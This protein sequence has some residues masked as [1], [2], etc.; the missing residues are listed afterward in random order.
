MDRQ[1]EELILAYQNGE[2]EAIEVI[3]HRYKK[4]VFNY[5]LRILSDRA[6]AEDVVSDIFVM[7]FVKKDSYRPEAKFSTWLYTVA[8]NICFSKLRQR[9]KFFSFW[10]KDKKDNE[11]HQLDIPDLELSPEKLTVEKETSLSVQKAL[12][13]L[14]I[15]QREA[16]VLREYQKLSYQEISVVMDCS[17]EKVKILIFRARETLKKNLSY[18]IKEERHEA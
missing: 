12:D 9:K 13:R 17:L 2:K 5:A 4:P 7:L 18:L 15:V 16:I 11:Y 14:P 1:D 10:V 8:R 3:F 6:E